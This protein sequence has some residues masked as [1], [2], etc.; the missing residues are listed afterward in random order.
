MIMAIVLTAAVFIVLNHAKNKKKYV[1]I[2]LKGRG[3]VRVLEGETVKK[4]K[5]TDCFV[6]IQLKKTILEPNSKIDLIFVSSL[7]LL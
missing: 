1:K 6:H 3:N 7:E 4:K 5:G 2:F